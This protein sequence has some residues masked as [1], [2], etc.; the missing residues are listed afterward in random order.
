MYKS[1]LRYLMADKKIDSI[2]NLAELTGVSRPP[3]DKLYKEKDLETLS[4][5]V[6]A[7]VCKYFNCKIEDLIEYIQDNTQD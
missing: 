4:L 7:R 1:K 5:D 6:L 3:L 2:K